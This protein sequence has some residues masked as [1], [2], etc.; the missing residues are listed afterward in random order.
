MESIKDHI[1]S[2]TLTKGDCIY[3]PSLYWVQS[4]TL[5]DEAMLITFTY[6][7]ASKLVNLLFK[8]IE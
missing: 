3:L 2:V 4:R 6:E 7:P 1:L 5:T 8:G